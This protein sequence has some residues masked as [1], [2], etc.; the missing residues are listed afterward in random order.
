MQDLAGKHKPRL[1]EILLDYDLITQEQLAKAL[2]RQ[3]LAG[4]RLGSI[5]EEMGY[6]GDDMLLSVLGRQHD[7]P[8]VNLFEAT[9]S[10]DVL[11]LVPFDQVKSLKILP[12]NKSNNIVFV[13]MVDPDDATAI[14]RI[15]SSVGGEVKPYIVPHHQMDKAISRFEE[16]GYGNAYFEGEKLKHEK[17]SFESKI[18]GIYTLLKLL[19]DFKATGLQLT[20]G[21]SPCMRVNNELRRLSMPKISAGQMREFAYEILKREQIEEFEKRKELDFVLPLAGTGRFRISLYKQRNSIS[22]SARRML[23]GIPSL[24]ELNIPDWITDYAMKPQG[25]ILVTGLSGDGKATTLSALVDLINSNRKCNIVTLEDPIKYLHKH[26]LSNVNQREIGIDTESFAE[27]LKHILR[28]APDVIVI[29]DL[30]D[31]ESIAAALIAAETGHLV[32]G[33]MTSLNTTSA[34][35]RILNIFPQNRQPQIKMQLADTLLLVLAQR[36]IPRK[37]DDGKVLAFEKLAGSSRVR[38]LIRDGKIIN[39]RSLMQVASEDMLSI[40]RSI[41]KLCLEGR[42]RF[43]DGLE[44]ADTPSYFQ[45]LI[46]TGSA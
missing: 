33:A 28:Q 25:L 38:N 43:E 31:T 9:V 26:K 11:R 1:G 45:D 13:A 41:A 7:L 18:P 20:A 14:Q 12:L 6:V 8:F 36:L 40:D 32:I 2:D 35:D 29:S 46:R 27:G 23:E 10:P 44:F 34:I 22:L 17:V 3:M 16:E 39:I 4:G 24:K 5:L 42:I 30:R 15:E 21:A 37:G 19:A